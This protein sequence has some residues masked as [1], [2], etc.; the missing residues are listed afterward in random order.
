MA[1]VLEERKSQRR[2][3][4]PTQI[5]VNWK[6]KFR[7]MYM[8]RL[9]P[10]LLL[11]A[12]L[13][14]QIVP[15]NPGDDVVAT[16]LPEINANFAYLNGKQLTGIGIPVLACSQ[17]VNLGVTYIRIDAGAAGQS[18]F[19]CAK[20]S[21][22]GY[23]WDGPYGAGGS[24]G[25][26]GTYTFGQGLSQTGSNVV[27]P[28]GGIT[29]V[30]LSSP[31][32]TVNGTPCTLG[33]ACTPA[34]IGGSGF[35][36]TSVTSLT[37]GTGTQTLTTQAGLAFI[38]GGPVQVSSAASPGPIG[39]T[40]ITSWDGTGAIT[41]SSNGNYGYSFTT[42]VSA[43]NITGLS[44][45]C[46]TGNT[47]TH[48]VYL[49]NAS[50]TAVL[51]QASLNMFGCTAGAVIS[52]TINYQA[53][54]STTY[55]IVS[56]EFVTGDTM[57]GYGASTSSSAGVINESVNTI[58]TSPTSGVTGFSGASTAASPNF[59]YT[60]VSPP[61]DYETGTVISY[62]GTTLTYLV[63]GTSG[64]GTYASWNISSGTPGS[65]NAAFCPDSSGSATAYVCASAVPAVTSLS[66]L[67]INL[68]P[69]TTN[70]GG[71]LTVNVA[72]LGVKNIKLGD[73]VTNPPAGYFTALS[74][75]SLAYNPAAVGGAG[76][77][78]LT[79]PPTGSAVDVC[80]GMSPVKGQYCAPAMPAT[81]TTSSGAHTTQ[82][83]CAIGYANDA[84]VAGNFGTLVQLGSGQNNINEAIV[85]PSAGQFASV[86]IQG[87]G[88]G[89]GSYILYTT[90]VSGP[91]ISYPANTSFFRSAFL[92]DFAIEAA[93]NC[94]PYIQFY[95]MIASSITN[96]QGIGAPFGAT[97]GMV[98]G[99][100]SGDGSDAS[101]ELTIINSTS[102]SN[103]V[104][105]YL[106]AVITVNMSGANIASY[107]V[108]NPGQGYP[109]SGLITVNV[110]GTGLN[111][112]FCAVPEVATATLNG[113]G[114][115]ASV[116]HVSG[117][118]SCVGTPY[119]SVYPTPGLTNAWLFN[120]SDSTTF[121]LYAQGAQVGMKVS[122]SN[123]KFYGN[124]FTY[125]VIGADDYG[126]TV[127]DGT[128][129]DETAQCGIRFEQPLST[130]GTTVVGTNAYTDYQLPGYSSFC[131]ASG[132]GS[133][134]WG[135]QGA[136]QVSGVN[137][138][139][140]MIISAD[141]QP[142][143]VSH[144]P[145]PHSSLHGDP[146]SGGV[147]FDFSD[148][149]YYI[150]GSPVLTTASV[151]PST[152]CLGSNSSSQFIAGTCSG[153][154]G[155]P[156]GF[157]LDTS[158]TP[159]S[160]VV[161]ASNTAHL[162]IGL[163]QSNAIAASTTIS[164]GLIQLSPAGKIV[165]TGV[166]PLIILGP[167]TSAGNTPVW[168]GVVP[169]FIGNTAISTVNASWQALGNG[170]DDKA[171]L[172][173][174]VT[175]AADSHLNF[176][177]PK[178]YTVESDVYLYDTATCSSGGTT[179][180]T[181]PPQIMCNT[182]GG[183][184]AGGS[185]SGTFVAHQNTSST[186]SI[187]NCTFNGGATTTAGTGTG[188][189]DLSWLNGAGPATTRNDHDLFIN[190]CKD[191]AGVVCFAYNNNSGSVA[192]NIFIRPPGGAITTGTSI[193]VQ[194]FNSGGPIGFDN[195]QIYGGGIL[196]VTAQT[197]NF[198][199]CYLEGGALIGGVS[200]TNEFNFTGCQIEVNKGTHILMNMAGP[201]VYVV[202]NI[203]FEGSTLSPT[204]LSTGDVIFSGSIEG[205]IDIRGGM[206]NIQT[207]QLAAPGGLTTP[208]GGYIPKVIMTNTK[209]PTGTLPVCNP[210]NGYAFELN[211]VIAAGI[212]EPF[213]VCGAFTV[214]SGTLT[215]GLI[216]TTNNIIASATGSTSSVPRVIGFTSGGY[217]QFNF[218]DSNNVLQS[219]P[220]GR[221]QLSSYYGLE[222][223]GKQLGSTPYVAGSGG[224]ASVTVYGGSTDNV[225][226][227]HW[228]NFAGSSILAKIDQAGNSSFNSV[229]SSGQL[230]STAT[231]ISSAPVVMGFT[232]A[233]YKQLWFGDNNNVIQNGGRLQIS[234]YY[235]MELHGKQLGTI[236]FTAG[237]GGDAS[238][239]IFG[240][241]T[242]NVD[243]LDIDNVGGTK[244][245]Y[246]DPSANFFAPSGSFGSSAPSNLWFTGTGGLYGW[247]NGTCTGT[248]PSGAVFSCSNAGTLTLITSAGSAPLITASVGVGGSGGATWTTGAG[249]PSGACVNGSLYTNTTGAAGSTLYSCVATAWLAFALH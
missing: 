70:A 33:A 5:K 175:A 57:L 36:G 129:L 118:T 14:A 9:L 80:Q 97:N 37:I 38:P 122:E 198:S 134:N 83:G 172:T 72:S 151:P 238:V 183:I 78:C 53:S 160:A 15:I 69:E 234:S 66:A 39:G 88:Y 13:H 106:P 199:N 48:I 76:A 2:L 213:T 171:A 174:M 96:V 68:L 56:Q 181:I 94:A 19:V 8:K 195:L 73:C 25:P 63:T 92:K 45:M 55:N 162:P 125:N 44:R 115:I 141:N 77:F 42:G 156:A 84:S 149:P 119:V 123:N 62:S 192:R 91:C 139:Y 215:V 208:Q 102:G 212:L 117:G 176:L 152:P 64:A 109:N 26:S 222:L 155:G 227:M 116:A 182:T 65:S 54:A 34:G 135:P 43:L 112:H 165:G 90:P 223:R 3:S 150:Q 24:G 79:S 167:V 81:C 173:V 230:V 22:N 29:N 49:L 245:A 232:T 75:Y 169:S 104:M 133:I 241:S 89:L 74:L 41:T 166:T 210:A 17:T 231:G 229:T 249:A 52:G 113:T 158:T 47:Q 120:A 67:T 193:A 138:G 205:G 204:G 145:P 110:L 18:L 146:Y 220:G 108:S 127:W 161:A 58:T 200:G 217:S 153:G 191:S 7:I 202:D 197:G 16:S 243:I 21:L 30:M 28:N 218:G 1:G 247:N 188:G 27:V 216:N 100:T 159:F 85:T 59:T 207:G 128:E 179:E 101:Q 148:K 226:I 40:F 31:T 12:G 131:L 142:V 196:N 4:E 114:G 221:V 60:L 214:L 86:S 184:Q 225:D 105:P 23:G 211:N 157:V 244:L 132:V 11:T 35:S 6:E 240:G 177:M 82:L 95:A 186:G 242:N 185:F 194:S 206:V 203:N 168:S 233:G 71:A 137:P 236:P 50:G 130:A 103:T 107:A 51:A 46:Q 144:I 140:H 87:N 201:G 235:G 20:T 180:C 190:N 126:N 10:V 98:I 99:G 228:T 121:Q 93:G 32:I 189:L 246:F 239:T 136:L 154:S 163:S 209:F 164:Y 147:G 178:V 111:D 143:D 224:D 219:S 170:S 61:P 237:S 187:T 124:H 248:I